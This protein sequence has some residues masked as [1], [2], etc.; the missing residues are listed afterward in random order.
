MVENQTSG[1]VTSQSLTSMSSES[2]GAV[3][4]A[5]ALSER[6]CYVATCERRDDEM[7]ERIRRHRAER[8]DTWH[9][10]EEP[11]AVAAAIDALDADEWD[12]ILLD[13]LTLWVANLM[14]D[15]PPED[16]EDIVT[17]RARELTA[18]CRRF[19]GSVIVVTN[20]V[21]A[22]IVPDNELARLFRDAAGRCNQAVAAQADEVYV[23]VSGIPVRIRPSMN[24][25]A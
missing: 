12:V 20:E 13:C 25:S 7:S 21:G 3:G 15:A 1:L 2:T 16:L 17:E 18:A 10:I 11:L 5:G 23:T 24:A 6:V 19:G 9:T 8:P 4:L 14:G 22:G